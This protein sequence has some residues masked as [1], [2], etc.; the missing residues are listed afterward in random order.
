MNYVSTLLKNKKVDQ[1]IYSKDGSQQ[2]L[3][4]D[5]TDVVSLMLRSGI[6]IVD[7]D[8]HSLFLARYQLDEAEARGARR[9][10]WADES[11]A[12]LIDVSRALHVVQNTLQEDGLMIKPSLASGIIDH[13][14]SIEFSTNVPAFLWVAS[15]TGAYAP[16]AGPITIS[17]ETELRVRA[18]S[19]VQSLTGSLYS[20][21][22]FQSY[23]V[24]KSR[25]ADLR[26]SEVYPSPNRGEREWVELW[27]PTDETISLL[28]WSIDDALDAGS[29][30][31]VF[32]HTVS[33]APDERR[34]FDGLSIAWNNSGDHVRL[35][36]PNGRVSDGVTYGLVKKG[37]AVA[38]TFDRN[39]VPLGECTTVHATP[40]QSNRCAEEQKTA[41]KLSTKKRGTSKKARS[42]AVRYVNVEEE[43]GKEL[44]PMRSQFRALLLGSG[45]TT[46]SSSYPFI[47]FS[48]VISITFALSLGL[49]RYRKKRH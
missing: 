11:T 12:Q 6:V 7:H 2:T 40:R 5:G 1:K 45:S 25:Y 48:I 21:E 29:K 20:A 8:S 44:Q 23:A 17:A 34:I 15:G 30:P 28:G 37:R 43:D 4:L 38:V 9:G 42:H 31:V 27:N 10:V 19:E 35:I 3:L 16:Y 22:S 14:V 46:A 13:G 41:K 26:I 24:R 36:D 18:E 32:S 47:V 33:L 49:F 39:G